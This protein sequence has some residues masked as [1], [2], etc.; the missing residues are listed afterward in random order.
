M[1]KNWLIGRDP[2]LGKIEGGRRRGWLMMSWLDDITN[3]MDMSLSKFCELVMDREVWCAA[4]HG[5]TKSRTWLSNW[6]ELIWSPHDCENWQTRHNIRWWFPNLSMYESPGENIKFS[7]C[8]LPILG[9]S[10]TIGLKESPRIHILIVIL[11][12]PISRKKFKKHYDFSICIV[13][14]PVWP[15]VLLIAWHI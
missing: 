14:L 9:N 6:T 3:L 5:V 7:D 15:H 1:W 2:G 12:Y 13:I 8:C 10:G 11:I 4:V